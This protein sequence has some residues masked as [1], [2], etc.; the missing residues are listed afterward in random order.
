MTGP[1][2]Q[3]GGPARIDGRCIG[4]VRGS[5]DIDVRRRGVRALRTQPGSA[6]PG[7]DPGGVATRHGEDVVR[8]RPSRK[9]RSRPTSAA[10]TRLNQVAWETSPL[11]HP[12]RAAQAVTVATRQSCPRLR[13]RRRRVILLLRDAPCSGT[14]PR[15]RLRLFP[16]Q[17]GALVERRIRAAVPALPGPDDGRGDQREAHQPQ[18]AADRAQRGRCD[19]RPL[20]EIQQRGVGPAVPIVLSNGGRGTLAAT[21]AASSSRPARAPPSEDYLRGDYPGWVKER[22][23]PRLVRSSVDSTGCRACR[24]DWRHG[25]P[26]R[27][28]SASAVS[29]S[30]LASIPRR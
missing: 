16:L 18:D 1:P 20:V 23:A 26:V 27:W 22:D 2:G 15:G 28:C 4:R 11:P 7:Q 6:N 3:V 19:Q 13:A 8:S 9:T 17:P 14:S 12:N 25:P 5:P 30:R 24:A 21:R 29:T 10:R